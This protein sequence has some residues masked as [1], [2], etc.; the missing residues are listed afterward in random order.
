MIKRAY[1]AKELSRLPKHGV[2]AQKIRAL[3]S[4][5]GT[6]YDFCRFYVSED[7]ILCET[8]GD[9]VLSEIGGEKHSEHVEEL[10][11]FLSFHGFSEVFCSRSLG[12]GLSDLLQCSVQIVNLMRF[13]GKAV[14]CADIEKSPPL[15]E[16]YSILQTAFDIDHDWWYVDMSHRI[17]HNVASARKLGRSA[18]V[19]QHDLNGEALLSQ[20]ATVPEAR[21]QGVA[22]RLIL[23]VC[24]ELSESEVYVLCEDR[25]LPFYRK[26]GFELV[27]VKTIL[28]TI[29]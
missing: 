19:I 24:A 23:S 10:A 9:F 2:E 22:S 25:L 8:D 12:E 13:C 21:G 3:L 7:F 14:E 27:D 5:Y 15:D 17:R 18:L 1:A 16:V 4:A 11:D 26:I 6:Q 20:I 28:R 29:P